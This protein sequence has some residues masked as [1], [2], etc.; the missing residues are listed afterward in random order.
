MSKS[1]GL[2]CCRVILFCSSEEQPETIAWMKL[3]VITSFKLLIGKEFIVWMFGKWQTNLPNVKYLAGVLAWQGAN[4]DNN[5]NIFKDKHYQNLPKNYHIPKW[6]QIF[7]NYNKCGI[8]DP[9]NC[10]SFWILHIPTRDTGTQG[11]CQ[12]TKQ[13]N[14]LHHRVWWRRWHD[15]PWL[16]WLY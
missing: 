14:Y 6:L 7:L 11:T 4:S 1:L 16:Q 15:Y 5:I 8:L 3:R 10:H 12:I 9:N 13:E 2:L